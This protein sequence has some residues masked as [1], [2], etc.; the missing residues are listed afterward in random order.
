MK[1][2]LLLPLLI[3]TVVALIGWFVGHYLS[4]RRDQEN[5]RRE[6]RVQHLL[7]AYQNLMDAACYNKLAPEEQIVQL[8]TK[9]FSNIQ[10]FGNQEQLKMVHDC[11]DDY[12]KGNVSLNDLVEDLRSDLRKE[13]K[14]VEAKQKLH[15]L[16]ATR[17]KI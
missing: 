16:T 1:L 12:S 5:K 3:T 6:L 4:S 10:L 11:I 9:A 17:K 7:V 15:W 8:A 2:D 13:L 14:L